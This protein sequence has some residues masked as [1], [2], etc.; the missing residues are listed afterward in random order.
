MKE[1]KKK[2]FNKDSAV[3]F[4][5]RDLVGDTQVNDV[6][7]KQMVPMVRSIYACSVPAEKRESLMEIAMSNILRRA[8]TDSTTATAKPVTV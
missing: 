2:L 8:M 3:E 6:F 1:S 5:I 7:V 4:F